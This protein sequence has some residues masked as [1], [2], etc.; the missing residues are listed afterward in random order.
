LLLAAQPRQYIGIRARFHELG[1][2]AKPRRAR[3]RRVARPRD[4]GCTCVRVTLETAERISR[5]PPICA[6][7][8]GAVAIATIFFAHQEVQT[9][10]SQHTAAAARTSLKLRRRLLRRRRR[11][12][13][14]LCL[15]LYPPLPAPPC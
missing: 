9:V 7:A 15:R 8:N 13:R 14:R 1:S 6:R 3:R 10:S 11:L 5:A 2:Q 4:W 12:R